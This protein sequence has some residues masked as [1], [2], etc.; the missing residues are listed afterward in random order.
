[1]S[2]RVP[3]DGTSSMVVAPPAVR[4]PIFLHWSRMS[5]DGMPK[6]ALREYRTT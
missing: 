6:A 2:C 4:I 5:G 1:M 3:R